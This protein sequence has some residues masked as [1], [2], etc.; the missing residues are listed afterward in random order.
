VEATPAVIKARSGR[1][2]R[3]TRALTAT[4]SQVQLT[5]HMVTKLNSYRMPV[6]RGSRRRRIP[7]VHKRSITSLSRTDPSRLPRI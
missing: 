7:M 2:W 5:S 6:N 3:S 1:P 4:A